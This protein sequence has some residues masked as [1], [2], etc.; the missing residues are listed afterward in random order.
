MAQARIRTTAYRDLSHYLLLLDDSGEFTLQ[1]APVI[2]STNV[3]PANRATQLENKM[4]YFC[5]SELEKTNQRWNEWSHQNPHNITPDMLRVITNLCVVTSALSSLVG[6]EN[7]RAS[8]LD[9]AADTLARTFVQLLTKTHTEQYKV[10]VVLETCAQNLPDISQLKTLTRTSFKDTGILALANHLPSALDNRK[11]VKQSFYAE[12]DDFMDM[13]DGPNSQATAGASAVESDLPRH[14]ISACSEVG[15]LYSCCSTY[16]HLISSVS[17]MLDEEPD[18]IPSE[19][20]V[21]L[22]SIPE[23]DLLQS[24]Q[25]VRAL[26]FSPFEIS[27]TDT[28]KLLERLSDTLID[29]RAREY[30]TSE[31][32]NGMMME[33]LTGTTQVWSTDSTDREVQ[34]L[35]DHVE[36]LY[37]YYAKG[38]EKSGVRRSPGLQT[39]IAAFLHG[40]LRYHPDF[41]KNR[42]IPSVRTSLFDLLAEG[43][44]TVKYRI[45][46]RLPDI[47]QDFALSEHDKI[48][49]D[50]DSSLPGDDAWLEGI[51]M[52]LLVLSRLAS[53]WHT[54]QRQ[55]IYRMFATAGSISGAAQH[56]RQCVSKVAIARNIG[57]ARSLFRLF[58]SQIIFTWLDR[59]RKF[60]EIPYTTFGYETLVDLLHDVEAEAVGQAIMLGR[61]D[62]IDYIAQQLGMSASEALGKNIAK[63]AAYTISWDTCVGSARNKAVPSSSNLLRDLIGKDQYFGLIMKQF[64]QV[65]GYILQT[66]FQEERVSKQFDKRPTFHDAS[67]ALSEMNSISHSE[68]DLNIG[69]EPAFS[70]YYLSDQL[71]RLCRRTGDKPGSFWTP[72]NYTLVMRMLLDRIHPALGSL[73]A[74]SIIRKLRILVALAG[75]VA[76]AGYPLQMCLQS[77]RPFLTDIQCTEDV[78]GIMQ[79]LFEHGSPYLKGNLGFVTGV[80]LSVLISIREFL[81]SSQESTT[82]QSQYIATINTATKFHGWFTGYLKSYADSLSENE[83][84]SAIKAFR[85]ITMAA[86]KVRNEGNSNKGSEESKLLM[87]ILEDA[88]SGRKLLNNTSR[89][90]ALDLLCQNFQPAATARDDVLGSDS[91]AAKYA[92]HVWD[93]CQR[94]NVGDGYLLWAARVL[95]RAFGAYGGVKGSTARSRPWSAHN[96]SEKDSL[97]R[98]SR[99]AI[100]KEIIDVFYSDDRSEVSLA[101]EAIRLAISRLPEAHPSHETEFTKI[102][103]KSIRDALDLPVA[104]DIESSLPSAT[105]S[106][107]LCAGFVDDKTVSIW[108]RDLAISLCRVASYEPLLG[109]LPKLLLGFSHVAE[110]LFPYILHLVLTGELEIGSTVRQTMSSAMK[111]W[112]ADYDSIHVPQVRILIQ[113]I[114]YLRSQPIPK[115][116]TRV[117]RDRWL[118]IDYIQVSRAASMSGMYRSALLFAETSGQPV[119]KPS[120]RSSSVPETPKKL[121]IDLQLSIYKNLDEP[122]SFYGVDRGYSLASVM[123]RVDYEGDGVKSLLFRGARL[124]SQIRRSN[125]LEAADSRGMVKSLIM[126]NMNSVTHSLLSN[127]Q[128]RD[129]GDDVVENTLHTARKLGQWDIKAPE[130]NHSEP[131]TL[132][133]AFQGLHYATDAV[134][135][136]KSFDQQLLTTMQYLSGRN[137]SSTSTKFRLRTLAVL[138][139]ADE[140]ISCHR[141][142]LFDVWD[143]MK[144]RETWMRAGE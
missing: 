25:F 52:R 55:C 86:S 106:V 19:F 78:V 7:P 125:A 112:F 38:M 108:I 4:L 23:S 46:E 111:A 134:A 67:K 45:A 36:A 126:L 74:R 90:V 42:K 21:Y 97:G 58:A 84:K 75:P 20:I 63:A 104:T 10:D 11:E 128:F 44:M 28:M 40:L 98:G 1:P 127:D 33:V 56:A 61:K 138:T 22:A 135:A 18:R 121:P 31:V 107:A 39:H 47:F 32:A 122:D 15:A 131:S 87:E 64:P 27:R 35:H 41:G 17:D 91:D 49:Q 89:E 80:G 3:S 110:R 2:N 16:L 50:V 9:S 6:K 59:K 132:F 60:D 57:D 5:L 93:S 30:N 139:E 12:D 144:G 118:D 88:R 26:I 137:S 14:D 94:S 73:Y 109:A 37:A 143:R 65:L 119:A 8:D 114:L 24:R 116:V 105:N 117:D 85:L 96:T 136:K 83:S 129:V 95:G 113:A 100:I 51:S 101:E 82:Q 48:L 81:G 99:E 103:P 79:Y 115:E 77:L 66:I 142:N 72:S 141:D 71:E 53:R 62:E 76:Y 133:K 124:D 140:V 69:I 68:L 120:R 70:A 123:D 13:D 102:I 54:I 43:E 92:P 29:P 34:D 130:M